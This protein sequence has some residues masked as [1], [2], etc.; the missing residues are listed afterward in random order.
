MSF[1]QY[2]AVSLF[3]N[4]FVNPCTR[5]VS[6][7]EF[8]R[9][10]IAVHLSRHHRIFLPP[11]ALLIQPDQVAHPCRSCLGGSTIDRVFEKHLVQ[12]EADLRIPDRG[13]R[14]DYIQSFLRDLHLREYLVKLCFCKEQ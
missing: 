7:D 3:K 5:D 2:I 9:H 1:L 11:L 6:N 14:S 4:S 8:H 12:P 10:N 13:Q